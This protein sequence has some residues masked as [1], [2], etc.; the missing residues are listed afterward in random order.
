[1]YVPFL[2]FVAS[3]ILIKKRCLCQD[4]FTCKCPEFRKCLVKLADFDSVKETPF[5][6]STPNS[7][8]SRA[9]GATLQL[10]NFNEELKQWCPYVS[11]SSSEIEKVMGTPGHRA[12]EVGPTIY[13]SITTVQLSIKEHFEIS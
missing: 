4:I 6:I 9:S 2:L 10:E 5:R 12:P 11:M 13:V 7:T 3:N 8:S 1:M